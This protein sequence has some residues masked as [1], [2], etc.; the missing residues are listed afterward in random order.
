[1]AD[2]FQSI[3]LAK[4]NQR[5]NMIGYYNET[6]QFV[7]TSIAM[8]NGISD[9]LGQTGT[10][11]RTSPVAIVQRTM[12]NPVAQFTEINLVANRESFEDLLVMG[13][14]LIHG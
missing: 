14:F 4:L 6:V 7:Q 10:L 5:V 1:M 2:N 13:E 11:K 8:L 3:L 12:E 9:D